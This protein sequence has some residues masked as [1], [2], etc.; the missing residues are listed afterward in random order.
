MCR[1]KPFAFIVL[2]VMLNPDSV[3]FNYSSVFMREIGK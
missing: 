3:H 2:K 1:F